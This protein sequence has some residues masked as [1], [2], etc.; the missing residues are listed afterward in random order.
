MDT[1]KVNIEG[2]TRVDTSS[3]QT[4]HSHVLIDGITESV[5]KDKILASNYKLL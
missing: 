5:R 2:E 3:E 1:S 4:Y